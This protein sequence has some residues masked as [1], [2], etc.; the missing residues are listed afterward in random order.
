ML[1]GF[2]NTQYERLIKMKYIVKLVM[3]IERG[4]SNLEESLV[5]KSRVVLLS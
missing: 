4:S 1:V 5:G 3:I 2:H